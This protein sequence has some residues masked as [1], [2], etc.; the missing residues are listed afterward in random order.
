VEDKQD[1]MYHFLIIKLEKYMKFNFKHLVFGLAV[2]VSTIANANAT[3]FACSGGVNYMY[4]TDGTNLFS[5]GRANRDSD[6][7]CS[8]KGPYNLGA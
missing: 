5:C 8:Y 7:I 2:A 4:C 3:I 1:D 6:W